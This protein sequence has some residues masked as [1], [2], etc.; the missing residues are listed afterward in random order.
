MLQLVLEVEDGIEV[1]GEA[2][3]GT[4]GIELAREQQ[5]DVL[6]LDVSMPVLDGLAALP[7]IREA[8]PGTRVVMLTGFSDEGMREQALGNGAA[9][10]VEKGSDPAAIT[11]AVRAAAEAPLPG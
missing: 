8:S 6:L 2:A 7:S 4:A 9:G 5:P 3:D 10:F 1:V 11:N